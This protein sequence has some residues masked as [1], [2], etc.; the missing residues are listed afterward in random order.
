[1]NIDD[2]KG[3]DEETI[4][5]IEELQKVTRE[6]DGGEKFAQAQYMIGQSLILNNKVK[7]AVDVW[8]NIQRSDNPEG[9]AV[10]N[11]QIGEILYQEDDFE[12]ATEAWSKIRRKDYPRVFSLVQIRMS[13]VLAKQGNIS[14]ALALLYGIDKSDNLEDY[15]T[16][17]L[18]IG[19]I[20]K[21]IGYYEKALKYW[22]EIE[23]ENGSNAYK[24]A[25]IE[26]GEIL[27]ITGKLDK[28]L[29]V[30]EVVNRLPFSDFQPLARL[31]IGQILREKGETRKAL[32]IWE[33]I[34]QSQDPLV[35]AM[36]RVEIGKVLKEAGNIDGALKAWSDFEEKDNP[37]VYSV[38]KLLIGDALIEKEL[39]DE[40]LKAWDG[41]NKSHSLAGYM[42]GQIKIGTT[43]I[44]KEQKDKIKIAKNTFEVSSEY[45]PYESSRY[46]KICNLLLK[47]EVDIG[48]LLLQLLRKTIDVIDLLTLDF[49]SNMDTLKSPERKLA[50]YTSTFTMDKLLN[51]ENDKREV[52][53]FR[54]NT[55]SNFNDPSEG[56]L[57]NS[58]LNG[59]K[60]DKFYEPDFD[61]DFHAFV[62]CFTFN[63]DSLNQFRLYGKEDKKEASGVS[64]VFKK[65]FFQSKSL[66]GGISLLSP[67]TNI[68]TLNDS[69]K[70]SENNKNKIGFGNKE[71][72]KYSVI[73]CIYIEPV[74]EYIQLAQRN[75]L[76]F[77]RE[78]KTEENPKIKWEAYKKMIDDKTEKVAESLDTL[79]N[80]YR[81]IRN[82]YP[83]EFEDNLILIKDIILPLKY[84]IKH[85]AFQEEQ[86]C[87]MI[88]ITSLKDTKVKMDF[89][90][91]LYIE[92]ETDVR[93][94]L[95]K[96]YIAPAATQYQPYLA[97]LL[98]D[99]N[100]KIE[101]S[102]NPY[103][104]T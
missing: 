99:T 44:D 54:L 60:K 78:F 101:L 98:C 94:N 72:A 25:Q 12:G 104:Q 32:T 48:R 69:F 63:H 53:P 81:N 87:R 13:D 58:Y 31:K 102:N 29:E 66:L 47:D 22:S 52:S 5:D 74:S 46:I 80:I 6:I 64:F 7:E 57:L 2:L 26:T 82:D 41:I 33:E 79:R 56:H 50:H 15:E 18:K 49:D 38:T 21:D 4:K 92:Y 17:H 43:L 93:S 91:F 55:V 65:D 30:L 67:T 100:V 8:K 16:A 35:Y 77:Y 89:G 9:H 59:S 85:S 19:Y 36:S 51:I 76:T 24:I 20:Y 27:R 28:A 34:Q 61:K 42:K 39:I 70:I 97:K 95:D 73:R 14:S 68:Q 88:H 11:M 86:E 45:Y 83:K 3:L 84:L 75:Q 71:S 90:K 40:A 37:E 96:V 10:A 23:K 1:M 103:R 62:S